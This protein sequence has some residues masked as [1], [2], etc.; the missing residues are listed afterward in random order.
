MAEVSIAQKKDAVNLEYL[1]FRHL[2]RISQE[3][4][5]GYGVTPTKMNCDKLLTFRMMTK[6]VETILIGD[7]YEKEYWD[8]V[9][10]LKMPPISY[11]WGNPAQNVEYFDAIN[12]WLQLL[13]IMARKKGYLT[14]KIS[15]IQESDSI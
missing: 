6:F 13:V 8:K 1:L 5:D 7:L 14:K 15:L 4:Q 11:T 12:D 2:D 9:K 3:M 10:G